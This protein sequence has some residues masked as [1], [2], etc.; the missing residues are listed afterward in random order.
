[1]DYFFVI[2]LLFVKQVASSNTGEKSCKISIVIPMTSCATK[3]A[4]YTKIHRD[5][6]INRDT[7]S[8]VAPN[9]SGKQIDYETITLNKTNI[10]CK[11]R[12]VCNTHTFA[13]PT[14]YVKQN[15]LRNQHSPHN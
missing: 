5:T 14:Q 8:F 2:C 9:R 12:T 13:Q 15:C 11:N 6:T 7:K 4:Y 10:V 3:I 1:M